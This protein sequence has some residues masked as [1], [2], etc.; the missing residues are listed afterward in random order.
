MASNELN[1]EDFRRRIK[2]AF[3]LNGISIATGFL[4]T[5]IFVSLILTGHIKMEEGERDHHY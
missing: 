4:V 3:I 1:Y 5:V 2:P